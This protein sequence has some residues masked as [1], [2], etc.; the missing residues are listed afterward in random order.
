MAQSL[1]LRKDFSAI[2]KQLGKASAFGSHL[3]NFF[4][5]MESIEREQHR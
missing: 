3:D 5:D 1:E 2:D 4:N